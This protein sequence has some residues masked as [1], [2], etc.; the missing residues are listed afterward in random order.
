M[1]GGFWPGH[2]GW[3]PGS[4]SRDLSSFAIIAITFS[5]LTSIKLLKKD[6]RKAV[7]PTTAAECKRKTFHSALMKDYENKHFLNHAQHLWGKLLSCWLSSS[8]WSES[9]H[10][11][12]V[13][14]EIELLS[15]SSC[16]GEKHIGAK[17]PP[18]HVGWIYASINS[19]TNS[20]F[21]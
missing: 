1:W 15:N 12:S 14:S 9:L 2:G 18:P 4:P 5:T 6:F 10:R 7:S 21:V 13:S 19:F 8:S 16:V 17:G 20:F 3:R 11:L